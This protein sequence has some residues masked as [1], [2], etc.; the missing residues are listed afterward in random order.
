MKKLLLLLLCV[1]LMFSCG[2]VEE[3]INKLFNTSDQITEIEEFPSSR[4]ENQKI[5][6]TNPMK[7][8]VISK[9]AYFFSPE[10]LR[11]V[12]GVYLIEGDIALCGE[13]IKVI[14]GR[15]YDEFCFCWFKHHTGRITSGYLMESDLLFED[16]SYSS[17]WYSLKDR[18]FVTYKTYFF[19][20]K[21][22][23]RNRPYLIEGDI[24]ICDN[25]VIQIQGRE[26]CYC[27]FKKPDGSNIGR[28]TTG[29]LEKEKLRKW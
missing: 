13:S 6:N 17:K 16:E 10:K 12:E 15:K 9:K 21:L 1:P 2:D 24:A 28:V 11:K 14:N 20:P 22:F 18:D 3:S 27:E 7:Y 19:R 4:K 29:Y 26:Y 25:D 23:D 8:E 5:A